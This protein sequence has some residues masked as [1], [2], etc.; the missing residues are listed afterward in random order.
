[1]TRRYANA[2]AGQGQGDAE[3]GETIGRS[4]LT[5]NHTTP[6]NQA[7]PPPRW[8]HRP[9]PRCGVPARSSVDPLAGRFG[10]SLRRCHACG[11]HAERRDWRVAA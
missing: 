4:N 5:L 3:A 6:G 9:C 2:P 7:Q 10:D 8:N 11:Q 1:M